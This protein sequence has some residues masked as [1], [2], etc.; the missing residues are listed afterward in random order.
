MGRVGAIDLVGMADNV[1]FAADG[2]A[3]LNGPWAL[4]SRSLDGGA[5][6][7][8]AGLGDRDARPVTNAWFLDNQRGWA[9]VWDSNSGMVELQA[10]AD[11]SR[12]WTEA[13]RWQ[14][15]T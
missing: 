7:A 15:D 6:W 12:T 9:V 8:P 5:T 3:W 10:T 13:A 14:V 4:L 2:S 1:G 11:G